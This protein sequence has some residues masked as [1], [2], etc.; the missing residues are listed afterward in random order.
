MVARTEAVAFLPWR[1]DQRGAV[2][3]RPTFVACRLAFLGRVS[4]EDQQ[5]PT[6]SVP[7]QLDNSQRALPPG[8]QI[9]V[10]FYDIESGRKDLDARGHSTAHERFA[11]PVR[12][13]GGIADLLAE[14]RRP[15]RRFDAVICESISR[16]ARKTFFG[17]K[18]EYDLERLGIP[19]YAADEPIMP[20]RKKATGV[21]TRR[22]KQ[23]VSE[24]YALE[25]QEQSWD[26]FCEHTRQGWNVGTPPYGYVGDSIPHPVPARR[27]EGAVKTRLTPDPVRAAAVRQM[28]AWRVN[29]RLGY[30]AIADKL[31][32]DT[33]RF[34]PPQCNAPS[35]QRDSWGMSSVRGI[36][37]NPKYTGFMVWNRRARKTRGGRSNPVS[38]WV[39][40]KEPT[41]EPIISRAMFEASMAIADERFGSR[42][43]AT[44]NTAHTATARIY[45][46]RG[47]VVCAACERRMFGAVKKG[48]A[49]YRCQP[50]L[51]N[52]GK[53]A[54]RF[55]GHPP[56]I[57]VREDLLLGAVADFFSSRIFGPQRCETL[58]AELGDLDGR[59]KE[60]RDARVATARRGVTEVEGRIARLVHTLEV[61]DDP[62]GA[63]FTRVQA[64]IGELEAER[65][66]RVAEL[67][68]VEGEQ[69][70]APDP[71]LLDRLPLAEIDVRQVP[72]D[73]QRRLFDAF[74]LVVRYH[75]DE[76][77]VEITA[78]IDE[79]T[80]ETV[81][82]A[83]DKIVPFPM[84]R[85]AS[86]GA[87][88]LDM[89]D[90]PPG[91]V[92]PP[93]TG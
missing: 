57:H 42:S 20:G 60:Q 45:P 73:V 21:L 35:R 43:E 16:V 78:V 31:N 6:L 29:E 27:S 32:T 93:S 23:G 86:E 12:R 22:V 28:F 30:R 66:E 9:T 61:N 49:Y 44:A 67:V 69:F 51:N 55:P 36:L 8:W 56:V 80:G 92:E 48:I 17:T 15:D 63:V 7:R 34:P 90:V 82:S 26:G 40:S 70:E 88:R 13:D 81:R 85:I 2:E 5:D 53:V 47:F 83:G 89:L 39:W 76:H 14:A 64:R 4:T 91:G 71:A 19:L 54:E 58:L 68:R 74:R 25:L 87:P 75:Q 38:E 18:V 79:T 10:H 62:T 1:T 50:G 33:E 46:L 77:A 59:A 24:W 11:I 65:Q 41:H 52:R 72:Q 3:A 84:D 37:L